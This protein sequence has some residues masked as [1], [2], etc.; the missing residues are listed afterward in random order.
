MTA[1]T[2]VVFVYNDFI[3]TYG[4]FA[5]CGAAQLQNYFDMSGAFF[6]N[7]TCNLAFPTGIPNMTRLAYMLTAHI[8]WLFAPRDGNGNPAQQGKI[9]PQT[10]GQV[11]SASEG[12]VS[13]SLQAVAGGGANELAAWFAQTRYGFM[14]WQATAQFRTAR[15]LPNPVFVPS[16]VYPLYPGRFGRYAR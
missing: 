7:N 4:E 12:T 9:A 2:P 16:S 8:A 14:Y 13:V 10:V 5:N 3:A 6:E 1:V 11:T 15:Y